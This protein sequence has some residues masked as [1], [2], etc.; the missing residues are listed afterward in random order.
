MRADHIA[1]VHSPLVTAATWG[2]LPAALRALG[3]DVTVV[4]VD[5]DADPPYASTYVASAAQQLAAAGGGRPVVLVGHSGAGPLLPQIGWSQRAA[6]RSVAGYV[7]LD[8]G[9]PRPGA[10]RLDLLEAEDRELAAA[11]RAD[12]EAGGL[13][14]SWEGSD[15]LDDLPEPSARAVVLAGMRPRGLHFFLE[16]LPHPDDWPDAPCGF[17]QTSETY[18]HWAR[19]AGLR[20]WT[21]ETYLPGGRSC[22]FSALRDPVGVASSLV[23]L[24]DRM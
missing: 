3:V 2:E 14:P 17:L 9:L 23:Q 10:S 6:R 5:V 22:H 4:R 12:L 16:P 15:L 20:G 1:L 13:F 11:F 24:I 8:A 7:F 18:A 19:V 21:V